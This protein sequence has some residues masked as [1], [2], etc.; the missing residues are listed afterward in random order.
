MAKGRKKTPTAIAKKL[1][2]RKSR[3]NQNEMKPPPVPTPVALRRWGK[4]AKARYYSCTQMLQVYGMLNAVNV[5]LIISYVEEMESWCE[6]IEQLRKT[7][8]RVI[9]V[10]GVLKVNP[11][12]RIQ[13]E[14]LEAALKIAREFGFTPSAS[15][16]IRVPAGG[17]DGQGDPDFPNV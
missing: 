17:G 9:K 7:G 13:K 15:A 4:R 2:I 14:S 10:E 6:A 1:N 12:H 11:W 8:G 5:D 16:G 3:I